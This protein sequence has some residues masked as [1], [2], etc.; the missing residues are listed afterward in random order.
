MIYIGST[1]TY[2]VNGNN[3][4][5]L[6]ATTGAF[7]WEH[8]AGD[9][10]WGM[11]SSPAADDGKIFVGSGDHKVYCF[12]AMTGQK[13]WEFTTNGEVASSPAIVDGKVYI[14]SI[15]C[16][17][18][19][20][21]ASTGA[22]V[23][24]S[25]LPD[26]IQSSPT[27][28]NG[29]VY[30]G[31]D[32]MYC[33]DAETGDH[34]WDTSPD[35]LHSS[36]AYYNDKIYACDT[37]NGIHC[38]NATYGWSIWEYEVDQADPGMWSSP[39]VADGK[40]YVGA[41]DGK[42]Y[43]LDADT[44]EKIWDYFTNYYPFFSSPA[45]AIC[46]VYIGDMEGHVYCFGQAD[47]PPDKPTIYGPGNGITGVEYTFCTDTIT[48]PDG[49]SLFCLWNWRDGNTSGWLGPYASGEKMC[50]SHT[51]TEPG[52]YCVLL[53]LKDPSGLES[54]WSEPF[55]VTIVENH[56]PNIPK[57]DGPTWRRPGA[58]NYTF[59]ATDPDGDNLSFF[60][61][62]GDGTYDDWFGPYS[63][64]EVVVRSHTFSKVGTYTIKVKAKD[65]YDAEGDWGTMPI[66]IPT[67]LM[68]PPFF[69]RL[70]ERFPQVFS[71]LRYLLKL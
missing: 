4:Y 42:V 67:D 37:A 38:L 61:D 41:C 35:F 11:Y 44:G 29:K 5:C 59:N 68:I 32:R 14:G 49:D 57:I 12:D 36:P 3:L 66:R 34:I 1:D 9:S 47:N 6:N 64:N 21:N 60:I 46:R 23:W 27:V 39:A 16:A 20:L 15:A 62:W 13:L 50:A 52:V 7:I 58:Y 10:Y 17:L 54:G 70:L 45:V 30:V 56:P 28:A 63:S 33:L 71:L 22:Q 65:I 26:Q 19:C 2:G 51:W 69:Y 53:K 18:Y 55:C 24:V 43:C 31:L 40:V 48:D 25:Y 8:S